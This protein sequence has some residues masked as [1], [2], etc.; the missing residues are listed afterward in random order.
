MKILLSLVKKDL[1]RDFHRPLGILIFMCIPVLTAAL[2]GIAFGGQ[3]SNVRES[4]QIHIAIMDQDEDMISRFLRMAGAQGDA[5]KNVI[6][7][8]VET[9]QEG[10]DMLE[11]RKASAFIVLPDNLTADLLD[12]T[13]TT[14]ELYK[15]PAES[16]LP[17]IVELGLGLG[18]EGISAG[19]EF[20]A[21]ELRTIR[22]WM[23]EEA[24][25]F[26]SDIGRVVEDAAE[27]MEN[28][29]L[30]I[31]PPIL[32]FKTIPAHEYIPSVSRNLNKKKSQSGGQ[33]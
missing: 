22:Q 32:T 27:K 24:D 31:S 2:L 10:L 4:I 3:G 25:P 17:Q 33:S 20:I 8:H 29:D 11:Q 6:I 19:L 5:S 14:I 16:V 30:Y 18:T 26:P 13:T 21:P 1:L 7:H 15:N 9:R 23:E 12:A 28:F